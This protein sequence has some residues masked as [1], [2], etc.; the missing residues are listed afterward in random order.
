MPLTPKSKRFMSTP[1]PSDLQTV[2]AGEASSQGDV[3]ALD[4]LI[5]QTIA[6]RYLVKSLL[7]EGGM[8]AVFLAEHVMMKKPVALK[9]LHGELSSNQEIVARFQREARAAA[10]I[11]HPNICAATDFGRL[12]GGSGA[13]FLVME[14]LDGRTL[15]SVLRARKRLTPARAI[16]I[17]DQILSV[18]ELAHSKGI[19]H[20]D[21]KPEN[22]MLVDWDGQD[23]VV[24]IMD[25]GIASMRQ[26]DEDEDTRLTRAGVAYGTPTYMSP[27]QVAGQQD[28]DGRAD[29]YT[30]GAMFF[31]ML[32]G[33]PPFDGKSITALMSQHLTKAPPTMS[34]MPAAPQFAPELEAIVKKMLE[35]EREDRFQD[36]SSLRQALDDLP[37][38]LTTTSDLAIAPTSKMEPDILITQKSAPPAPTL[39]IEAKQRFDSLPQHFQFVTLGIP[40][41]FGL[42]IIG[43]I[44][45]IGLAAT[46]EPLPDDPTERAAAKSAETS[47]NLAEERDDFISSIDGMR[48]ALEKM[49]AGD[50]D[51]ARGMLEKMAP[52]LENNPHFHYYMGLAQDA[53][54]KHGK[55]LESFEKAIGLDAR[56]NQDE[57]LAEIVIEAFDRKKTREKASAML[58]GELLEAA[59]PKLAKLATDDSS[60]KT[61]AAA[62]KLLKEK[63]Q[64]EA[65]GS[66]RQH[67]I[68]F[69]NTSGCS[70]RSEVIAKLEKDED[71]RAL[72]VL[73]E[74]ADKPKRGCG[75]LKNKDCYSCIRDDL[76]RA[77]ETLE[78]AH[79]DY[80]PSKEE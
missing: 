30:L 6:D 62:V 74:Y 42:I 26:G 54:K 66:W 20:R 70:S 47:K 65:L 34:E 3:N 73:R 37:E 29:I 56:Y 36:A 40:I 28:I 63:K 39:I 64:W 33:Q 19:V 59:T 35:K 10:A 7:G 22:V 27:E 76:A 16:H 2:A 21:L 25:F 32:T 31:E 23:D 75:L 45:A 9:V 53:D 55:A 58:D 4:A 60:K 80:K 41:L 57:K 14:Y 43:G 44:F 67:T 78:K 68:E 11:N 72:D 8:G 12:D 17:V 49:A 1:P 50:H 71:P 24:K 77:I 13:F 18:L 5:G 79:P 46:D 38:T 52:G 61:R 48:P 51:E 69:K 15:E